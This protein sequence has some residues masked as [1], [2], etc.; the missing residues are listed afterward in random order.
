MVLFFRR[1]LSMGWLPDYP[2]FRDITIEHDKPVKLQNLGQKDSVKKMLAKT[3]SGKSDKKALPK[4]VSLVQWFSPVEDQ[5]DLGSCTANAGVGLVEYFEHVP[6]GN[7]F[8]ASRLFLYKATRSAETATS[9]TTSA[10]TSSRKNTATTTAATSRPTTS[11]HDHP[12]HHPTTGMSYL[13]K[14]RTRT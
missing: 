11:R 7:T 10:T 6:S 13:W 9:M 3:G 2:D 14:S 4:S 12:K 5:G 1:K 8:D